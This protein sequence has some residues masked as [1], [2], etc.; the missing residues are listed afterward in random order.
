M[1][2]N[3][4]EVREPL[5]SLFSSS[6]GCYS[7]CFFTVCGFDEIVVEAENCQTSAAITRQRHMRGLFG[8]RYGIDHFT[9]KCLVAWPWNGSE[10]GVTLFWKKPCFSSVNDAVLMLISSN[11]HKKNSEVSSKTGSTPAS[12]SFNGQATRHTTV[13]WSSVC[14]YANLLSRTVAITYT[15]TARWINSLALFAVLCLRFHLSPKM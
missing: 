13:K 15:W 4:K 8:K 11:L 7:C 10:A 12:L 5:F 3:L 9:V 1:V 14:W 2:C 6:W